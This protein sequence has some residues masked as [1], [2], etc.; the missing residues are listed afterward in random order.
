M[1]ESGVSARLSERPGRRLAEEPVKARRGQGGGPGGAEGKREGREARSRPAGCLRS[2]LPP[3]HRGDG[4]ERGGSAAPGSLSVPAAGG[5]WWPCPRAGEREGGGPA[6]R[7]GGAAGLPGEG[8]APLRR[9]SSPSSAA[10]GRDGGGGSR[11]PRSG[12]GGSPGLSGPVAGQ[13]EPHPPRLPHPAGRAAPR[14]SPPSRV[15][16]AFR[17]L[18]T[19]PFPARSLFESLPGLEAAGVGWAEG[20]ALGVVNQAMG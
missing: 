2:E 5:S 10:A 20:P 13:G 19:S 12:L 6:P 3:R 18:P 4:A 11:K 15:R 8:A 16:V 14:P 9:C 1:A 17:S 7:G